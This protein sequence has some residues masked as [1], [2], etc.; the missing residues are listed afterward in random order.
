MTLNAAIKDDIA[1]AMEEIS[2]GLRRT[3][4]NRMQSVGLSRTK[5]RLLVHLQRNKTLNQSELARLL[6]LERAGV[7]QAIDDLEQ[8]GLVKR[9]PSPNDR[10]VW[11][12]Q[13]CPEALVILKRLRRE[14]DDVYSTMW[15]GFAPTDLVLLQSHLRRLAAQLAAVDRESEVRA[16]KGVS[17]A[18]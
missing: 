7:G 15:S 18:S 1:F 3:F 4:D 17:R 5:W 14:A 9:I 8:L 6:E 10:R 11:L 16:V 2:R 13:L 12:I